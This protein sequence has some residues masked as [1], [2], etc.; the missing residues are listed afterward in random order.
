MCPYWAQLSPTPPKKRT[1]S[2]TSFG[3]ER[4]LHS[5]APTL[6]SGSARIHSTHNKMGERMGGEGGWVGPEE[7][8]GCAT[9][10]SH[11]HTSHRNTPPYN[12]SR[13]SILSPTTEFA[14]QIAQSPRPRFCLDAR[15]ALILPIS[16]PG[17]LHC[18]KDIE[19]REEACGEPGRGE[20]RPSAIFVFGPRS[21]RL[22][23]APNSGNMYLSHR[24]S[25]PSVYT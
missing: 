17:R 20:Y 10:S 16:M 11:K 22:L 19:K 12:H 7:Q 3:H 23:A 15:R 1:E 13:R 14:Q 4:T 2:R 9:A 25:R 8:N 24:M 18:A 6:S 5:P 21:A